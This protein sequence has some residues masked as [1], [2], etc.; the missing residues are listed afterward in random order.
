MHV[1]GVGRGGTAGRAALP[2]ERLNKI[3]EF[4]NRMFRDGGAQS[5]DI[6]QNLAVQEQ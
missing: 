1:F 5:V 6:N 2:I 4:C 3:L